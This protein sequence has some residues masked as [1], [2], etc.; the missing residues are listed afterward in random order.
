LN[1]DIYQLV[2]WQPYYFVR[3]PGLSPAGLVILYIFL[4][5]FV[6]LPG[7][8]QY[9]PTPACIGKTIVRLYFI[10]AGLLKNPNAIL[11]RPL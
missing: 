6:I 11:A 4:I 5:I 1:A 3:K 8:R 10:S 2:L 7:F 9:N